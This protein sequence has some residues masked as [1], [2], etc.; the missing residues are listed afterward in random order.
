MSLIGIHPVV[1]TTGFLLNSLIK[2]IFIDTD[3]TIIINKQ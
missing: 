3:L 1:K 2:N